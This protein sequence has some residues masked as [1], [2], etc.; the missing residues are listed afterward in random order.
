MS[1]ENTLSFNTLEEK[2][3]HD[4]ISGKDKSTIAKEIIDQGYIS[5]E[6]AWKYIHNFEQH[7][8]AG[9]R[10]LGKQGGFFNDLFSKYRNSTLGRKWL[11]SAYEKQMIK[12]LKWTLFCLTTLIATYIVILLTGRNKR[13]ELLGGLVGGFGGIVSIIWT[14]IGFVRWHKVRNEYLSRRI[15]L[16]SHIQTKIHTILS[17]NKPK[18]GS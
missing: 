6:H 1:K 10:F 15:I 7:L 12:G 9:S 14:L 17:F 13:I 18:Y 8:L 11:K 3:A 2:L 16:K 4:L 5:D